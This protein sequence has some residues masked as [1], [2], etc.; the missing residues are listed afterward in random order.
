MH[1]DLSGK[2]F[3]VDK[4]L[5]NKDKITS[6]DLYDTEL[7]IFPEIIFELSNLRELNIANNN[8]TVL[9]DLFNKITK[10][11]KLYL[12]CKIG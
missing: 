1:L 8:I 5:K 9:P 4:I 6:L 7:D 3:S 12:S 10:I 11:E 2:I